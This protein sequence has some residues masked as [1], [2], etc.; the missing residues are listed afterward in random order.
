MAN[1]ARH[2]AMCAIKQIACRP[3]VEL[4]GCKRLCRYLRNTPEKCDHEH[5]KHRP[6]RTRCHDQDGFS[7]SLVCANSHQAFPHI[8]NWTFIPTIQDDHHATDTD[9]LET[10]EKVQTA[11]SGAPK[12]SSESPPVRVTAPSP[13]TVWLLFPAEF[14]CA[15]AANFPA[16]KKDFIGPIQNYQKTIANFI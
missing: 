16:F 4:P 10:L 1:F 14:C 5:D 8:G 6:S 15:H 12:R 2:G 11:K 13:H 9:A 3:M 7:R